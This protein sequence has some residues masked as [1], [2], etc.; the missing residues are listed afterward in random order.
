MD[1]IVDEES[2]YSFNI[3]VLE[4]LPHFRYEIEDNYNV[5]NFDERGIIVTSL[6]FWSYINFTCK[7][8]DAW[9][10]IN[11]TLNVELIEDNNDCV[12][13]IENKGLEAITIQVKNVGEFTF[14]ITD[15]NLNISV[16]IH[17]T[18]NP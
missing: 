14:T 1:L 17:V 12:K 9:E 10:E 15:T 16:E 18:V 6:S 7:V 8:F 11:Q 5:Y 2:V 3:E 4:I 13:F